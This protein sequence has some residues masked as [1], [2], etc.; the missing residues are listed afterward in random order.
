MYQL[1]QTGGFQ[2]QILRRPISKYTKGLRGISRLFPRPCISPDMELSVPVLEPIC[3][4][5]AFSAMQDFGD[6]K[7]H[8]CCCCSQGL[9]SHLSRF[10]LSPQCLM[11]G[12]RLG[13]TNWLLSEDIWVSQAEKKPGLPLAAQLRADFAT[14]H[15]KLKSTL[16]CL[17]RT[18]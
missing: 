9:S 6:G 8:L 17:T 5:A 15:S 11:P 3:I 16:A 7:T 1:H 2:W 12:S 14:Q 13:Q 4:L 18:I 10:P